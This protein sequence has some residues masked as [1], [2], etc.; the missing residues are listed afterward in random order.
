MTIK[1]VLLDSGTVAPT[2]T[3]RAPNFAHEWV[4]Y[5]N[6]SPEQ[7]LERLAGCA[8]AVTN[9][10]ALRQ[11][12]LCQ[13]PELRMIAVAATGTDIIDKDYAAQYCCHQHS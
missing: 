13:L 10:V 2:T 5:S 11:S 9:K 4:N 7:V 3:L 6:T 12:Q 1:I 8:I